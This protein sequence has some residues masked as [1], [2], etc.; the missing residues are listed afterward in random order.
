MTN[1]NQDPSV[2]AGEKV[3]SFDPGARNCSMMPGELEPMPRQEV[4]RRGI[5]AGELEPTTPQD[6]GPVFNGESIPETRANPEVN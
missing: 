5:M 2:Q 4:A 3:F 6:A 1:P